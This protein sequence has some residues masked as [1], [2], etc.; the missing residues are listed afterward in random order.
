MKL[1]AVMVWEMM[2][3]DNLKATGQ[4]SLYESPYP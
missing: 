1:I 2:Q 4:P 3:E